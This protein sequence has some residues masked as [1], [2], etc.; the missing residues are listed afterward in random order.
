VHVRSRWI[1]LVLALALAAPACNT[2]K[3]AIREVRREARQVLKAERRD[4]GGLAGGAISSSAGAIVVSTGAENPYDGLGTWI[5]IYDHEAWADPWATVASMRA[6]GVRTIYLQTSNFNRGQ[7]FVHAEEVVRFLDAAAADDL[8]VVAWYLPGFRDVRT[9]R[10]R[11][12]AAIRLTTPSGNRFASFALDIESPEVADPLAR[13]RRLLALSNHLRREVGP[14]YRLGAIVPSPR[15]V[16]TDPYYWSAFPYREIAELYDVFL[17]MTYFTYRVA[18]RDGAAWYTAKNILIL[19]QETAGLQVPIH[20]IGGIASDAT[21]QE[22][23]GFVDTIRARDVI[24]AS[25]YTFPMI[26]D[27]Q[28]RALRTIG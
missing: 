16:R 23:R 24:G 6:V 9:D 4:R 17:P 22:T 8:D 5:D 25:Y 27:D 20:V 13:T 11:A 7:P 26:R 12:L 28:W 21:A 2:A 3:D 18:G 19:R 15:R 14:N 10:K 1:A